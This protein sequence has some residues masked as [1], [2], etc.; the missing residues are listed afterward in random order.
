MV[1][2]TSITGGEHRLCHAYEQPQPS[3]NTPLSSNQDDSPLISNRHGGQRRD[4]A[5]GQA[6]TLP[7]PPAAR[8]L[9]KQTAPTTGTQ[10]RIPSPRRLCHTRAV[11]RSPG[12][13][14]RVEPRAA[15]MAGGG[16][17][18]SAGSVTK[19]QIGVPGG[20]A[21]TDQQLLE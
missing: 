10:N 4:L 14:C 13:S 7:S 6:L 12:V 9:S 19:G 2:D 18:E 15:S 3:M 17:G 1:T 16:A 8:G 20:R 21:G 11:T 5:T